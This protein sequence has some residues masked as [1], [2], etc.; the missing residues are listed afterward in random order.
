MPDDLLGLAFMASSGAGA[1]TDRGKFTALSLCGGGSNGYR[2]PSNRS[3][4]LIGPFTALQS[5]N[6]GGRVI[7]IMTPLTHKHIKGIVVA[8]SSQANATHCGTSFEQVAR[9]FGQR[10]GRQTRFSPYSG[11]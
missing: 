1:S 6:D 11:F 7:C 4:R 5:G 10:W 2:E 8:V 3:V 9:G